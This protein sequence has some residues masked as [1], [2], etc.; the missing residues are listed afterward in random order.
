MAL[1]AFKV[2]SAYAQT[3]RTE[4]LAQQIALFNAAT[5]G[6]FVLRQAANEGDYSDKT[7][8]AKL[9]GL[10]RRRNAYGTGAVTPISL[11][12]LQETSVKVAAGTPPI[13]IDPHTFQW[14]Q[15]SPE[16]AGVVIGKQ[17]AEEQLADYLNT[18]IMIYKAAIGAVA[19][20]NYAPAASPTLAH[21]NTGASKFGDRSSAIKCWVM[22][23]STLHTLYG[24]ALAN[25]AG[26]FTF[27]T[28]KVVTDGFGRPFVVTDSANLYLDDTQD[29]YYILGL[30]D[31][32]ILVEENNDWI[33]NTETKN[34]DENIT[35]TYQAQWSV[36]YAVK[37]FAW[38]KTN[39][40]RS[41]S[42]AA[43]GTATNWDKYVTSNKDAAGVMVTV[44]P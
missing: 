29:L 36:N 9:S 38:D 33:D 7:L 8:W 31:G 44:H 25:S 5:M 20:L 21:L 4:L 26:L 1:S 30:S 10:V 3:T 17:L 34:G 16:E 39:G 37:G 13:E 15:K 42:N 40:G 2:F 11:S 18:S 12:Q 32:A 22:H 23:S 19:A 24:T 14:I 27:G 28:V 41:P 43:L 35:R 6:G